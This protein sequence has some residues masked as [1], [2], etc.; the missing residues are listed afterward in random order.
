MAKQNEMITI[1]LGDAVGVQQLPYDK[2]H[3]LI[4]ECNNASN[5]ALAVYG[6]G[7]TPVRGR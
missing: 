2:A 1:V 3:S 6:K 5:Y 7:R 4:G